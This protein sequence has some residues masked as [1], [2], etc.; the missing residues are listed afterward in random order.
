MGK[1]QMD[2]MDSQS[3]SASQSQSSSSSRKN[4]SKLF[5]I[6]CKKFNRRSHE[7]LN[8]D[9][10]SGSSNSNSNSNSSDE[11]LSQFNSHGHSSNSELGYTSSDSNCSNSSNAA[12]TSKPTN[13]NSVQV[14]IRKTSFHRS[15]LSICK[16]FKSL[17]LLTPTKSTATNETPAQ[18]QQSKRKS[19]QPKRILR[20]PMQYTYR[21]GMSG[22]PQRVPRSSVC[23]AYAR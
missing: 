9:N 16:A 18:P 19:A 17:S 4:N 8:C 14:E 20:Q 10:D 3:S 12:S 21:R 6:L 1:Q 22:L 13:Q 7:G 2:F 5:N 23:C 11:R 15:A